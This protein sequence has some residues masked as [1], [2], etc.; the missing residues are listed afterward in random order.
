MRRAFAAGL[1][2]LA[3]P[4]AAQAATLTLR[5][6]PPVARYG[7]TIAFAGQL[8]PAQANV[9]VGLYVHTGSA[10]QLVA[11]GATQGDGTYRRPAGARATGRFYAVGQGGAPSEE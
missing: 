6:E 2:L 8:V 7:E 1:L 4:G 5:A 9:P 3:L 10:W 11:S